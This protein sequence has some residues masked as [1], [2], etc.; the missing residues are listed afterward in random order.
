MIKSPENSPNKDKLKTKA[1]SGF[2]WAFVDAVGYQGIQF[3]VLIILA[4][5]LQPAEFGLIAML[6]VFISLGQVFLDSGFA[7]ALIQ[8][9]KTNHID[10]NSVF[11]FNIICGL[12]LFIFLWFTAPWI[13]R[14]YNE[15]SLILLTRVLSF[16]FIVDSFGILHYTLMKRSINFKR[17]AKISVI[18]SSFSGVIAILMAYNDYGVWSL[19]GYTA[20]NKLSRVILYWLYNSWRPRFI[21]SFNSLRSMFNYGINILFVS[22]LQ[23]LFNN[24]YL[25]VIGKLFTPADLGFYSRANSL[26]KIPVQ[27]ISGILSRVTFPIFS[28]IQDEKHKLKRG[29]KK[30]ISSAAFITFPLMIGMYVSAKP[31]V[32]VLLTSKWLPLVPYLEL[33]CFIG[34]I[35]PLNAINLNVLKSIG[36]SKLL[37][38]LEIFHKVLIVFA[39]II[40]YQSGIEN[41]IIGQIAVYL[42]G[43]ICNL[44]FVGQSLNY[45][46]LEQIK[47]IYL[48]FILSVVMGV[49]IHSITLINI[50]NMYLLLFIEIIL[51]AL[52][53]FLLCYIFKDSIFFESIEYLRNRLNK[54]L[55]KNEL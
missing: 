25:L 1:L 13:S 44:Y 16:T 20:V 30:T 11:Y 51:G 18:A 40:T 5:I 55:K 9:K 17:L 10:E 34:L 36:K 35:Y 29:L 31:L 6:T 52:S 23:T 26:Q 33:L 3:V 8:K 32:I 21:F 4:R 38:N 47:D 28:R 27:N 24:I 12:V 39:I 46:V 50:Y 22:L 19:V 14:F 37:L 48:V 7:T 45:R 2:I 42:L 49:F 53:Y 54:K 41:M 43:Y 15:P